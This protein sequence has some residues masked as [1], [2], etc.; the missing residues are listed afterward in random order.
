MWAIKDVTYGEELSFNYCSVT[1]SE[2]EFE[3][4]VCLCASELCYGRYLMLAGDKK[5][6][7]FIKEQHTFVDR[8]Y[9]LWKATKYPNITDEDIQ[10]L[11][12]NSIKNSVMDGVPNWL[13]KWACLLCEYIQ[14]EEQEY[15][16]ELRADPAI[17]M[18]DEEKIS[19]AKAFREN[20]LWNIAI[21]IN[22]V[23]HVLK[24]MGTFEPPIKDLSFKERFRRLW[25]NEGSLKSSLIIV[26]HAIEECPEK[27]ESL[28]LVEE[29]HHKVVIF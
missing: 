2:K 9:L 7:K 12:N 28:R 8:N 23:M 13:M 29:N 22:K 21:T 27:H 17:L 4:A 5:Q 25:E 26:L 24:S 19:E 1:E 10:R 3:S 6:H 11:N 20:K 16:K 14:F 18:K 15:L